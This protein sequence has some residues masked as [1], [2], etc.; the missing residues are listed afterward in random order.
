M[1]GNTQKGRV[2]PH[3]QVYFQPLVM[4]QFKKCLS[5]S[6]Q[7]CVGCYDALLLNRFQ[8]PLSLN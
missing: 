6:G 5:P 8:A 1:M 7:K 3:E 2:H 4:W